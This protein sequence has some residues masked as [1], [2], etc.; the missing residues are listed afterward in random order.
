MIYVDTK[1]R[2]HTEFYYVECERALLDSFGSTKKLCRKFNT[3]MVLKCPFFYRRVYTN[4][5]RNS[6][7]S[8]SHYPDTHIDSINDYRY[9]TL[10]TS[11]CI[12]ESMK[13]RYSTECSFSGSGNDLHIVDSTTVKRSVP[14]GEDLNDLEESERRGLAE[15]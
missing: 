10:T 15:I 6:F 1:M 13:Q 11:Y 2:H 12:Q 7:S 5:L 14:L 3:K 4:S 9:N 8:I